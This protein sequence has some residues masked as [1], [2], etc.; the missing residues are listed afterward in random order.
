MRPSLRQLDLQIFRPA[1][2][3]VGTHDPQPAHA[4]FHPPAILL[5]YFRI[6]LELDAEHQLFAFFLSFDGFGR[7]LR[8]GGDEADRG[9]NDLLGHRIQNDAGFAA[10]LEFTRDRRRQEDRHVNVLQVEDGQDLA[11][12]GDHF[13]IARELILDSPRSRRD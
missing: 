13:A 12:G 7:E 10:D 8:V 2:A 5:E 9:G 6:Q 11:A 1:V 4:C 3:A